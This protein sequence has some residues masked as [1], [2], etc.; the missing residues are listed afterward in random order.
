MADEERLEMKKS[1]VRD[2]T[3]A[4]S[5]R[6]RHGI[7][8]LLAMLGKTCRAMASFPIGLG[9]NFWCARKISRCPSARFNGFVVRSPTA[10]ELAAVDALYA[11]LTNGV[12]LGLHGKL[13][14]RLLGAKLCLVALDEQRGDMVGLALF[15]F[16]VRDRREDTVHEGYVG[17]LEK[18]RGKG[19]GSFMVRHALQNFARSGL[20]GI[21]TR[22]SV[23]NIVSLKMNEAVGFIPVET[24]YDPRFGEERH[25]LV[26]DLRKGDWA[27]RHI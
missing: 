21:S 1:T 23:N 17:L 4:V 5:E 6:P 12:H 20:A 18:K 3:T 22:I 15:Y 14:L 2:S 7:A 25:Y 16:N 24:Y 10:A 13:M 19:L 11:S 8:R 26:C 27:A 9:R